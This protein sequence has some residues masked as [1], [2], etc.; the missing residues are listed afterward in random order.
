MHIQTLQ[1]HAAA[2]ELATKVRQARTDLHSAWR[3]AEAKHR[4]ATSR[5]RRG[6]TC[7]YIFEQ[8]TEDG[9]CEFATTELA[10]ALPFARR[11]TLCRAAHD[12][13]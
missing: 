9:K 7:A 10:T 6:W 5:V 8:G 2:T 11:P 1:T 12:V 3:H 13:Q 4:C